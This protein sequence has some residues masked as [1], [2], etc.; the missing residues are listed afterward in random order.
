MT[1]YLTFS[2]QLCP[3]TFWDPLEEEFGP[4]MFLQNKLKISVHTFLPE[5]VSA[6]SGTMIVFCKQAECIQKLK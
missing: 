3:E 6:E 2:L 1:H 5:T 4:S